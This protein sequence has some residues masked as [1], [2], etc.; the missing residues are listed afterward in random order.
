MKTERERE[1]KRRKHEEEGW[2]VERKKLD[3][4]VRNGASFNA[5]GETILHGFLHIA[6]FLLESRALDILSFSLLLSMSRVRARGRSH[7]SRVT[8]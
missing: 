5:S 8:R 4:E 1:K 3:G 7:K 6:L 2:R